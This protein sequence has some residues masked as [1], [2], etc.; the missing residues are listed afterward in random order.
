[1]V[2]AFF[3]SDL[4]ARGILPFFLPFLRSFGGTTKF[5]IDCLESGRMLA[6]FLCRGCTPV[7]PFSF[8]RYE[9]ESPHE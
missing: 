3:F 4:S 7:R 2:F 8:G 9:A 1:V 5:F 6:F